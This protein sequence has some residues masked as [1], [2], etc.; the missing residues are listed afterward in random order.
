MEE[1]DVYFSDGIQAMPARPSDKGKI[2][3]IFI[4]SSHLHLGLPSGLF[5]SS[6]ST[7]TCT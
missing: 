7:N 5:A 3:Y 4:L 2:T 6:F 1:I